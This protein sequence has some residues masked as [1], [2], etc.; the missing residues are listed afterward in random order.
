MNRRGFLGGLA[1]IAGVLTLDPE[2]LLWRPGEKTI[3]VPTNNPL[4]YG[5]TLV[6][7]RQFAHFDPYD[8]GPVYAHDEWHMARLGDN[9]YMHTQLKGIAK[10][11][12]PMVWDDPRTVRPATIEEMKDLSRLAGFA[13]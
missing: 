2:R 12:D 8:L 1:A 7:G 4:S 6:Q 10:P 9:L 3:F 11:G 13:V 5:W